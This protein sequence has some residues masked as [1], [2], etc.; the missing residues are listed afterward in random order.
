MAEILAQPQE[1]AD[2][3]VP[4]A[5]PANRREIIGDRARELFIAQGFHSV[6]MEDIAAASDVTARAL[7]RHYPNKLTL[8]SDL[9]WRGQQQ[10]V[11]ALDSIPASARTDSP[12]DA[13]LDS[14]AEAAIG[15]KDLSVLWQREA[16]YLEEQDR[17]TI[18]IRMHTMI[19]R[20]SASMALTDATLTD[21]QRSIRAWGV[22]A[23]MSSP[24]RR[25]L[26][27]PREQY[28]ALL[29]AASRESM[30]GAS[31]TKAVL[32]STNR[33]STA[34][35]DSM[36]ERILDTSA[37]LFHRQG[38]RAVS[39][40]DIGEAT[41]LAGTGIYRYFDAKAD[42]LSTLISRYCHWQAYELRRQL[43]AS[44][45][46]PMSTLRAYITAYVSVAVRYPHLVGVT[47]TELA[48]VPPTE[49][50]QLGREQSDYRTQMSQILNA[51]RP[52]LSRTTATAL[53]SI[54]EALVVD[55]A[56]V[57]R[58]ESAPELHTEIEGMAISVLLEAIP[59]L[60]ED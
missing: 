26:S 7:Y 37:C 33:Q 16:R 23:I 45:P 25:D 36:R 43:E 14:I 27:L 57:R 20:I 55:T 49:R 60:S 31:S 47:I 34:A 13:L 12:V 41:G 51:V 56:R 35:P 59:P 54:V 42:I 6:R 5:R 44:Q 11:D 2:V 18:R 15:A 4:R 52:E 40:R 17:A 21:T 29:A 8:L 30:A 50:A 19:D 22:L 24:G 32:I 28:R 1:C 39:L 38:F 3:E 10:Y 58:L 48:D 46:T 9:V 53:V